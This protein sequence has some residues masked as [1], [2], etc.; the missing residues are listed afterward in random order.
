MSDHD[1]LLAAICAEPDEDT[2]RLAY[3]DLIEENGDSTRAAFIRTQI[4]IARAAEYDP[5]Y[6][7]AKQLTPDAL[8]GWL[9]A[10]TLPKVPGGYGWHRFEFRRGFPWKLRLLSLAAFLN[11]GSGVFDAAPIQAFDVDPNERPNL[12]GS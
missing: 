8:H 7:S 3:A 1:A 10:H 4:A 12:V 5:V 2:P 6:I 9:L 11:G